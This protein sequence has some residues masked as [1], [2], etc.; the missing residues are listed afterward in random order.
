VTRPVDGVSVTD[1]FAAE[2][3]R[4][5]VALQRA[6]YNLTIT[7]N[8]TRKVTDQIIDQEPTGTGGIGKV[9]IAGNRFER[10]GAAAQGASAISLAGNGPGAEMG[11]A[12]IVSGN[13]I[14]G[15]IHTYNVSRI[16]IEHNVING[17]PGAKK[18]EPVPKIIKFTD[19]LRLIGNE[20]ERP[21]GARAGAVVYLGA[22][23]SGWPVDVTIALN[24]IRQNTDG[25]LVDMEGA[26]HVTI[27]DNTLHCN[28][29]TSGGFSAIR[30]Q[31][32]RINDDPATPVDETAAVP[33]ENLIVA[34]NRARGVCRALLQAVPRGG[35]PV[36][37]VTVTD[38]QTKGFRSGVEFTGSLRPSV[39]PR[40][41]DNL[42]EGTPPA[43][44]VK[45]PPGFS[46]EGG[47]GPE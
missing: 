41:T 37:A 2:C 46:F 29:P 18:A 15:G 42:F 9:I 45:G 16:S 33:L 44:F 36:G 24:T 23:G 10:G 17:Q 21:A 3:D 26:Q 34:R 35:V 4:S 22:H 25:I 13:V 31:S 28:Q 8:V 32:A 7:G 39:K 12:M 30:G 6:S 11:D 27:V 43:S 19:G 38:N 1:S 14:D 40:I 47:N 5:F 20:I